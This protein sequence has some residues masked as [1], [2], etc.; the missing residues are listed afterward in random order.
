MVGDSWRTDAGAVAAGLPVLLLPA[1]AGDGPRG[2]TLVHALLTGV[3]SRAGVRRP[4]S[5]HQVDQRD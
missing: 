4:P 3:A 5:G 2:L 1:A